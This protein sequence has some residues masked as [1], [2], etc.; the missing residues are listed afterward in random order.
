MGEVKKARLKFHIQLLIV[1]KAICL[2]RKVGTADS[3]IEDHTPGPHVLAKPRMKKHAEQI[4]RIEVDLCLISSPLL[5]ATPVVA[6]TMSQIVIQAAPVIK[7]VRRP[8]LSSAYSPGNV[9]TKL[10]APKII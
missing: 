6:K 4:I 2:A 7:H 1:A 5:S 9:V 10:T 8:N 3:A